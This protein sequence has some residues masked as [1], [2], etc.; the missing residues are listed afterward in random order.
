[1]H[2]WDEAHRLSP[3][4]RHRRRLIVEVVRRLGVRDCLDAGC[5]QPYLLA[6]LKDELDIE[7]YGCDISARTMED[8]AGTRSRTSSAC[9]TSP[10][11]SGPTGPS[12]S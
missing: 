11:R 6:S 4:P 5:G 12:T 2:G 10:R 1:M 9:S 3:A 7:T 8:N